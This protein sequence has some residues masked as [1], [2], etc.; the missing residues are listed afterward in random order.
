MGRFLVFLAVASGLAACVMPLWRQ[1]FGDK[2]IK[3]SV[4]NM[5]QGPEAWREQVGEKSTAETKA[6]DEQVNESIRG[7]KVMFTAFVAGPALLL[8]LVLLFG[9][10]GMGRGL[11][12]LALLIGLA[13]VGAWALLRYGIDE[14]AKKSP[15]WTLEQ[16]LGLWLLLACG[17]LGALA[18]LAA[19]VKPDPRT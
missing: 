2:A 19:L 18:G 3:V 6:D 9:L 10:K 14:A 4:M 5:W 15:E 12:V 16:G 8:L 13:G 17:A 11:G 1:S 7:V